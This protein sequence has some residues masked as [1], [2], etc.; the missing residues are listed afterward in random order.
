[1]ARSRIQVNGGFT[2]SIVV[3]IGV[4]VLLSNDDE[5]GELAYSWS[6]IDQ[7]EGTAD[8]LSNPLI[9][10]PTFTPKKEGTY[11]LR[12]VVNIGTGTEAV[13]L[14]IVYVADARTG[15]RVP[16]AAETV[17]DSTTRG[18]AQALNRIIDRTLR[19]AIEGAL[20]AA[21]TPGGLA[22]GR[23]VNLSGIATIN[24]SMTFPKE[25]PVITAAVGGTI[26]SLRGMLAVVIDG[27]TPGDL[28]AGKLI[29]GR[30]AG[31]APLSVVE[32]GA[33]VG[34]PVYVSNAG[35][36]SLV[37]GTSTRQIGRVV[38]TTGTEFR[39]TVENNWPSP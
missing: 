15:E 27:V 33:V 38:S 23:L 6:I 18:W 2:S 17:E 3:P 30:T 14:C 34:Q 10:N 12:L 29:L 20:V 26:A 9:E 13:D 21:Q 37:A 35:F 5:G 24:G 19:A 25:V 32:A 16:A 31:L 7:P 36:P 1:M 39:W 8:A 4:L 28:G 11:L 22:A